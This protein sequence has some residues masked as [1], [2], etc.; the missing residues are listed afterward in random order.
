MC[1]AF[2]H[3]IGIVLGQHVDRKPHVIYY[4]SYTLNKAQLDYT[5]PAKQFLAI[6]F[7]FEKYRSYLIGSHVI[8][9]TDHAKLNHLFSKKDTKPKLLRWVLLL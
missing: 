6:V 4:V 9:Y 5:M 2:E 1:D 8:F 7:D 3:A